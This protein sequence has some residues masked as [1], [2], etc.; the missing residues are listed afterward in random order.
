MAKLPTSI[1]G[2]NLKNA[3]VISQSKFIHVGRSENMLEV[4]LDEPSGKYVSIPGVSRWM[5]KHGNI[6]TATPKAK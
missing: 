4:F 1:L 2:Y 5:D 3:Q 6:M